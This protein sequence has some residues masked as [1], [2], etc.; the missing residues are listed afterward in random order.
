MGMFPLGFGWYGT[1]GKIYPCLVIKLDFILRVTH[2][3][4]QVA[5]HRFG[6]LYQSIETNRANQK[7]RENKIDEELAK[8]RHELFIEHEHWD[9]ESNDL[10][11]DLRELGMKHYRTAAE[12]EDITIRDALGKER[13]A[14][15]EKE[16][17]KHNTQ[18]EF[19]Y[20]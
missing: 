6:M 14:R 10:A 17:A 18:H 19:C 13:I 8:A 12:V 2:S 3:E 4:E 15:L 9:A 20:T 7:T 5:R 11:R 1:L 16:E